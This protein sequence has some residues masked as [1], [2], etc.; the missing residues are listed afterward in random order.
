M[1]KAQLLMVIKVSVVFR[2]VWRIHDA[3]QYNETYQNI[4]ETFN[5]AVH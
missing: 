4:E 1:F 2:A 3:V 5:G